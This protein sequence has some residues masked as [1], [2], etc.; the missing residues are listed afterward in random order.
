M[1]L[2]VGSAMAATVYPTHYLQVG[3]ELPFVCDGVPRV[4]MRNPQAGS[5]VCD[6]Y[7]TASPV[8]PKPSPS[9]TVPSKPIGG[10]GT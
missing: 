6:P 10:W 1:L 9:P 3:D 4:P 8:E 5:V 2:V 7:P